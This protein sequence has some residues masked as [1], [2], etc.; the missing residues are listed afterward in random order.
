M[1]TPDGI[2]AIEDLQFGRW[3]RDVKSFWLNRVASAKDA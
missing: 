3:L 2:E 1:K